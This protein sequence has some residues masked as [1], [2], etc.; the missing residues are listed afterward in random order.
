MQMMTKSI[1]DLTMIT[2]WYPT[3][4]VNVDVRIDDE[5]C[6]IMNMNEIPY[7]DEEEPYCVVAVDE[8]SII[9]AEVVGSPRRI[10]A[11]RYHHLEA[12]THQREAVAQWIVRKKKAE[13]E[14]AKREETIYK[15]LCAHG[16]DNHSIE[17]KRQ[18]IIEKYGL[19]LKNDNGN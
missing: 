9:V 18:K 5:F 6:T 16:L 17:K 12:S 3:C 11:I 10:A 13:K 8:E 15:L 14:E 19:G 7:D 1:E 4:D 2:E